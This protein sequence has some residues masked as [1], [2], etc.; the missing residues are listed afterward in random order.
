MK[1]IRT[2]S[3]PILTLVA[4]GLA[5]TLTIQAR[6]NG[7]EPVALSPMAVAP[8][9]MRFI[10]NAWAMNPMAGYAMPRVMMP[11][12]GVI[13]VP[14]M[15][16]PAAAAPLP[17]APVAGT[18]PAQAPAPIATAPALPPAAA[19]EIAT[20]PALPAETPPTPPA[21]SVIEAAPAPLKIVSL[22]PPAAPIPNITLGPVAPT[23]IMFLPA[24]DAKPVG[25]S[26]ATRVPPKK[27]AAA[28]PKTP[29]LTKTSVPKAS[30][31]KPKVCWDKGVVKPC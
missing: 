25:A 9:M 28:K 8:M 19:T 23:P 29:H 13:W 24:P 11:M 22:S 4:L 3:A 15:L 18:P 12:P 7:T 16:I 27:I 31:K 10:P 6:A 20:T 14:F 2:R 1:N 30:V 17:V 21:N 5:F 26:N